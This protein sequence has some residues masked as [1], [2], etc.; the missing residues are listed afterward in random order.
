MII[1]S[2]SGSAKMMR[3][4]LIY[5][6]TPVPEK[7]DTVSHQSLICTGGAVIW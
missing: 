7:A 5:I 4:I 1:S 6:I 2:W 3:I